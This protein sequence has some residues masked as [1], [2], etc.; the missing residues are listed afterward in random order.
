MR[1]CFLLECSY[2]FLNSYL[3]LLNERFCRTKTV[4]TAFPDN[5]RSSRQE[6][7]FEIADLNYFKNLRPNIVSE[8]FCLLKLKRIHHRGCFSGNFLI[9]QKSHSNTFGPPLR[10]ENRHDGFPCDQACFSF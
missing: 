9:F 10:T 8:V 1:E 6:V 3:A 4:T 5:L 7:F 2:V